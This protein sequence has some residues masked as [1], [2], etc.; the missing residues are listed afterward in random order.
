MEGDLLFVNKLQAEAKCYKY[1]ME[2]EMGG[3]GRRKQRFNAEVLVFMMIANLIVFMNP[4]KDMHVSVT[5]F[6]HDLV[7]LAK[8]KNNKSLTPR[9]HKENDSK[10]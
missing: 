5:P 2:V 10:I 4:C 8:V 6:C 3:V 1:K 7:M 9:E